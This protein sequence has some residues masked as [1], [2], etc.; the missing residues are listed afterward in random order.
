ML[1]R[2]WDYIKTFLRIKTEAAMDPEIEIEMA[3]RQAREQD[4][5]LRNQAAKVIAHRTKLEGQIDDAADQVGKSRQMA[6]QALIKADEATTA[7]NAEDTEKWTRSAQSLALKLQSTQSILESLKSQYEVA[8][9]AGEDAKKA[10]QQ[11]AQRVQELASKRMELLGKLEQAKMQENVNKAVESMSASM[12]LDAPSLGK[13]DD[14]ISQRL[15]DASAQAELRSVTPE[16][17]EAELRDAMASVEAETA[18]DDL[19]KEL[20]L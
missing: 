5:Q 18:L 10:V 19:R 1:K 8:V 13:I 2:T 4:Q 20:G 6:K 17:A 7:G 9:E 16:G 11:N 12:E 15:A 3:I 14:K